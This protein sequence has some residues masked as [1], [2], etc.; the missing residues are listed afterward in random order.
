MGS[1]LRE[2][3]NLVDAEVSK[4]SDESHKGSS[5]FSRTS[6]SGM[7][8]CI[9]KGLKNPRPK[10][11]AGSSPVAATKQVILITK[12]SLIVRTGR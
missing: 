3:R 12:P 8:E 4:A 5:P 7:V 11:H 1:F 6:Y 2:W 10:G 9:H